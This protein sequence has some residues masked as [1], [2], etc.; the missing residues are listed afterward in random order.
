[1]D[2]A[3]RQG[4]RE[5][6]RRA[7]LRVSG[8]E[9]SCR[10]NR[11]A[12]AAGI[13]RTCTRADNRRGAH[14]GAGHAGGNDRE[15][16]A[17]PGAACSPDRQSAACPGECPGSTRARHCRGAGGCARRHHRSRWRR[18]RAQYPGGLGQRQ[19]HHPHRCHA[20]RILGHR[21]GAQEARH[22]AATGRHRSNHRR[23][24]VDRRSAVRRRVAV[25]RRRAVGP[26]QR[27]QPHPKHA[28]QSTAECDRSADVP[29]SPYSRG[30]TT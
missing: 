23:G 27:R 21:S 12:V 15:C 8:A 17:V 7:V 2:R 6:R 16:P 25:P 20:S 9:Q 14:P 10:A 28:I 24:E 19:Q 4:R 26:R 18:R 13:H 11:A 3:P 1:M 22:P 5:R 30:S 29:A